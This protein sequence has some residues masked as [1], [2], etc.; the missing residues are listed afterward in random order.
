VQDN[1][2]LRFINTFSF[3]FDSNSTCS[4]LIIMHRKGL[5]LSFSP[6]DFSQIFEDD[7]TPTLNTMESIGRYLRAEREF[8]NLSL[9]EVSKF[10]RIR[11]Q[12]LN[13]IEEDRYE[14]LPPAIYV[15]GYLTA[16]ARYLGLDPNDMVLRY[17]KYLKEFTISE[18][19]RL[20][21]Q[22]LVPPRQVSFSTKRVVPY[23]I[24][25]TLST[26]TVFTVFFISQILQVSSRPILNQKEPAPAAMP[27]APQIQGQGRS[28]TE[29][30]EQKKVKVGETALSNRPIFKVIEAG[31]GTVVYR[32][33][34]RLTLLGI[35]REFTCNNQ[36]IYF[37][38]KIKTPEG[39]RITHVWVWKGKEYHR[40]EIEVKSP[41]WSVYSYVTLHSYQSG[42]WK[43]EV[44][45]GDK[46]LASQT[47]N[48]TVYYR[49]PN[50]I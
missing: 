32:E 6:F 14:L 35:S 11:R 21:Q 38:T 48:A 4:I 47:F 41:E 15:K 1:Y 29:V 36:K 23:L 13:A 10:T 12:F 42:D 20:E 17:Q 34:G 3:D 40:Y 28:Q 26:M 45:V 30:S 18:E 19:K 5:F 8:R 7:S 33:G 37:L 44:R 25:A 50:L 39:G 16:Y 27:S 9:E 22:K 24:L 2:L 31:I 43:V 49:S 46:V